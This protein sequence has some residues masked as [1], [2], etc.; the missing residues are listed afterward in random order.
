MGGPDVSTEI[1]TADAAIEV[2]TEYA[3]ENCVGELGDILDARR[4]ENEWIV[5]FRTHTYSDAY[6]H[7]VRLTAAVGN[8]VSHERTNHID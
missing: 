5:E 4:E 3:D 1:Q 6:D 7:R 8:V 2:A